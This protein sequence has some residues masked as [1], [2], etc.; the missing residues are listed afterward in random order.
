[1]F[2]KLHSYGQSKNIYR[3]IKKLLFFDNAEIG[4]KF[5]I[6]T[7]IIKWKITYKFIIIIWILND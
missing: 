2:P 4:I 5:R 7:K 3:L 1:M 6:K